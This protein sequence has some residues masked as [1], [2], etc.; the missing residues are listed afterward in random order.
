M[1]GCATTAITPLPER[2]LAALDKA[3]AVDG[4]NLLPHL[5]DCCHAYATVGEMV[6]TLKGQWGE[7]EEPVRL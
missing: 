5:I 6:A 4:E 7:F 2:S 1:S 3:A